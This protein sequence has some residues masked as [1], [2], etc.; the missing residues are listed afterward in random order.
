MLLQ[1]N[2]GA[3]FAGKTSRLADEPPRASSAEGAPRILVVA[4]RAQ[5]AAPALD[6][7]E[8]GGLCALAAEL[9]GLSA[10]AKESELPEAL[11]LIADAGGPPPSVSCSRLVAAFPEVPVLVLAPFNSLE[12]AL[13]AIKAGADVYL[14]EP[15]SALELVATVHRLLARESDGGGRRS[16]ERFGDMIGSSPAMH[17]LYELIRRVSQTDATVLVTGET[18]TGKELVARSIHERSRRASG[19][20]VGVNCAAIPESL[21]ESELFGHVRGAFTDAKHDRRGLFTLADSGTLFLDEITET[22]VVFQAKLLRALQQRTV[23]PVG[24][25]RELPFDV[26]VIAAANRDLEALL[27]DGRF[28]EDLYYR[29]NVVQVHVPPLR[30]RCSDV[31]ELAEHFIRESTSRGSKRVEGLTNQAVA[32]LTAYAWP[33]NVRELRNCIESAVAFA[34]GPLIAEE[35]LPERVRRGTPSEAP[36]AR[37]DPQSFMTLSELERHY[38]CEV[39]DAVG[40]TKSA[41]ARILGLDR[42]T[43]YRKLHHYGVLPASKER[44]R[45]A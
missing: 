19:P 42:K 14:P 15:V 18:G 2:D 32:R 3:P 6:V 21:L 31:P 8:R 5:Q 29:L 38:I 10:V 27:R 28:R 9:A 1:T 37:K 11:V 30:E 40:G 25:C 13:D 36:N 4:E 44:E 23:R 43:L 35:D 7:L 41:A 24:G 34:K 39:L 26:R 17:G 16:S 22:P 20:F 33:G 45:S 12:A